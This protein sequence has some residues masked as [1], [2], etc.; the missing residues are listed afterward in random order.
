MNQFVKKVLDYVA[1]EV[2]IK[3]LANSR[4][5][6]QFAV[7]TDATLKDVH[8]TGSETVNKAFDEFAKQQVRGSST[9]AGGSGTAGGVGG[10]GIIPPTPPLRGF[11]GFVAAFFKEIQKDL[12]VGH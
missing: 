11:P 2:I 5:F 3:G 10:G 6:Q 9:M 7:R 12:G 8:R 1:N 4:T